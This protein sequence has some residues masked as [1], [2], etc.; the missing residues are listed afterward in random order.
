MLRLM[1][2]IRARFSTMPT[3]QKFYEVIYIKKDFDLLIET[4]H[5]LF[6]SDLFAHILKHKDDESMR[7]KT[8]GVRIMI[9]PSQCHLTLSLSSESSRRQNFPN[10]AFFSKAYKKLWR[11]NLRENTQQSISSRTTT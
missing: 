8:R 9:C 1:Q 10:S 4:F 3:S 2:S 11:L 7:R 5:E 6:S